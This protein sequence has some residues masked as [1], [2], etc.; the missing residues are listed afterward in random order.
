MIRVNLLPQKRETRA[1]QATPTGAEGNRWLLAGFGVVAATAVLLFLW[2][3]SLNKELQAQLK[4]NAGLQANID[5]IKTVIA[6]H[7]TIKDSLKE[8]REREEAVGRLQSART[9]PTTS[10]L[11]ISKL[12][13]NGKGPTT[14]RDKLE[15]MKRDNPSSVPNATWDPR[16]LWILNYIEQERNVRIVG[17]ARDG[18]DVSEFLRRIS[19]SD[20]FYDVKL[21]PASKTTDGVTKIELV[22]FELSAKV[23]Y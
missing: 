18:E 1:T 6:D 22:R 19:L 12:L 10:L 3:V 7:E 17:Q 20:F 8:L 14:D 4:A 2:Y 16:R 13:T 23:R 11:E 21:L 15:Q 5:G 9:G